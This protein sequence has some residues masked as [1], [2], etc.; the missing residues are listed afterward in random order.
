MKILLLIIFF[1]TILNGQSNI[2]NIV[3]SNNGY[4]YGGVFNI[5]DNGIDMETFANIENKYGVYGNTWFG[6]IDYYTNTNLVS[7]YSL[8]ISKVMSRKLSLD[9]GIGQNSTFENEIKNS[10]EIYI[11]LD[12][13][14]FSIYAFLEDESLDF[15]AWFKPRLGTP[16][17][18]LLFYSS[19]EK[20][21]YEINIDVSRQLNEK[22]ITG[23]IFGFESF[24]EILNYDKGKNLKTYA[25]TNNYNRVFASIYL[26]L[27]YN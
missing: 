11:G 21:A 7:N 17:L 1:F 26:G 14:S 2:E 16:N 19:F 5:Y 4:N 22:L 3:I 20:G 9:L 18:D 12:I 25:M 23:L 8:G 27:L 15:E 13:N 6:Q 10:T 24:K